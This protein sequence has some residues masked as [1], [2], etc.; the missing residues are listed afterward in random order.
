MCA[1]LAS[2]TEAWSTSCWA[3]RLLLV[4]VAVLEALQH[5]TG[6]ALLNE[7]VF[8]SL[9]SK[10]PTPVY[11]VLRLHLSQVNQLEHRLSIQD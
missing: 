11:E 4:L 10:H 5:P 3:S 2:E 7:T 6:V 8:M 1:P 9:D